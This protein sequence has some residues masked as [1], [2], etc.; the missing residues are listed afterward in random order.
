MVLDL[1]F[2]SGTY[3]HSYRIL[4]LKAFFFCLFV[5]SKQKFYQ[6]LP[7]SKGNAVYMWPEGASEGATVQQLNQALTSWDKQ[8]ANED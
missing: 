3:S 8:P 7:W 1:G 4:A 6:C 5:F 2:C